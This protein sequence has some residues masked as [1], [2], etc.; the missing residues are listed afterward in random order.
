MKRLLLWMVLLLPVVAGAKEEEAFRRWE[1]ALSGGL[2]NNYSWEVEP[3]FTFFVC[4]YVGITGGVNFTGQFYDEYYSGSAPGNMRWYI[5][6]DE[7]NVKRILF[8]PALRLRTPNIN[9]WGDRDLKVTFNMEPG[10]YM[11]V[12]A[13]ETLRVGYENEKH[14]TPALHTEDVTNLNGDWLYW[15]VR[16]FV[17]IE[18]ESWVFSA[19]YTIS[20]Y[21]VYGG[22]RNLVIERKPLN[23]MLWKKKMTHSFFLSI[24]IQF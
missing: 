22:R 1:F 4:R 7:S 15:N 19:G 5:G 12:P 17:Q 3:A 10:A 2:N 13:N 8:R 14:P 6:S 21:D 24:G 20:N 23:D 11:V 9:R 16:S 18:V